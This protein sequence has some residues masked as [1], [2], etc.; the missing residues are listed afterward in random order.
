[1]CAIWIKDSVLFTVKKTQTFVTSK[2]DSE[3][4]Y[5]IVKLSDIKKDKLSEDQKNIMLI[6]SNLKR[7]KLSL[8]KKYLKKL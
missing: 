1:M 6:Y 5:K 3:K 4:K 2:I 8:Y 7:E